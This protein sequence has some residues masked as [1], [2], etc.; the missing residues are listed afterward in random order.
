MKILDQFLG[1]V[2]FGLGAIHAVF[3]FSMYQG[4]TLPAVWFFSGGVAVMLA[5]LVNVLRAR[6]GKNGLLKF[7]S[8]FANVLVLAITL[9]MAFLLGSLVRHNPQ[10]PLVGA[11]VA[12]ELVFSVAG[13]R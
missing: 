6:I 4:L 1:W 5:G 7:T 9:A 2:M 12:L 11:V 3:T 10:V 8:V 13:K